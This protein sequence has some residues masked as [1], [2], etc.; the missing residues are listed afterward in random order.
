MIDE[1]L[2]QEYRQLYQPIYKENRLADWKQVAAAN[3]AI[4]QGKGTDDGWRALLREGEN[5]GQVIHPR[6]APLLPM[7]IA[8]ERLGA[9]DFEQ[10]P[11]AHLL[12]LHAAQQALSA[13]PISAHG[14]GNQ[15]LMDAVRRHVMEKIDAGHAAWVEFTK[16]LVHDLE[17]ADVEDTARGL[18]WLR[19]YLRVFPDALGVR[20]RLDEAMKSLHKEATELISQLHK[21]EELLNQQKIDQGLRTLT[22]DVQEDR[23]TQSGHA[24]IRKGCV[25]EA[26]LQAF[27]RGGV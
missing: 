18:T 26:L 1:P 22:Y 2:H 9:V 10:D 13:E 7:L 12:A 21:A 17:T 23:L 27:G 19:A 11:G 14:D 25:L 6:V 16:R 8:A 24:L 5:H 15:T 4:E 3:E 20:Q